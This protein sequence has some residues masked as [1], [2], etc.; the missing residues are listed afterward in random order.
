MTVE[1]LRLTLRINKPLD[2]DH[3]EPKLTLVARFSGCYQGGRGSALHFRTG[4]Q[5]VTVTELYPVCSNSNVIVGWFLL[6][7]LREIMFP[8]RWLPAD[9]YPVA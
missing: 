2:K 4:L 9:H 3:S 8:T 6:I 5:A 1:I 7:K